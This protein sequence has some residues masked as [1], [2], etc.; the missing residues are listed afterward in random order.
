MNKVFLA[1]A[2]IATAVYS[3]V[4]AAA[5]GERSGSPRGAAASAFVTRVSPE[6]GAGV[7]YVEQGVYAADLA[8]LREKLGLQ[9]EAIGAVRRDVDALRAERQ[10]NT[11]NA[12]LVGA[13]SALAVVYG[14]GFVRALYNTATGKRA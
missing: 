6:A 2:L 5:E 3:N 7:V 12:A 8:S 1:T 11:I 9:G 14:P 10:R 13:A 4:F